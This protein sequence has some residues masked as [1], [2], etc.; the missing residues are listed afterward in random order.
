MTPTESPIAR[1]LAELITL[2]GYSAR[3]V[4][5]Q[6]GLAADAVRNIIVGRSQ[7]PR[8]DTLEAIAK[9]LNV[10]LA[11]LLDPTSPIVEAAPAPKH[12]RFQPTPQPIDEV[13]S[14]QEQSLFAVLGVQLSDGPQVWVTDP[15]TGQRRNIVPPFWSRDSV[16]LLAWDH[17]DRAYHALKAA[18]SERSEAA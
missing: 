8:S 10:T 2:R 9:V 11:S 5:T 18:M 6:A 1:R 7:A 4:A 14:E 12:R 17:V 15:E 13:F 16:R 3:H